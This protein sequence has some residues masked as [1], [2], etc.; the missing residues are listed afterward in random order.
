LTCECGA[1]RLEPRGLSNLI[2][3]LPAMRQLSIGRSVVATACSVVILVIASVAGVSTQQQRGMIVQDAPLFLLPDRAREPLLLMERGVEV[4]VIRR[5]GEW[6]NVTVHG[7]QWGDRTG[8]VEAKYLRLIAALPSAERL[9][10]PTPRTNIAPST[11]SARSDQ[12]TARVVRL[13]PMYQHPDARGGPILMLEADVIVHVI[14]IDGPW[15]NINVDGSRSGTRVGY[16]EEQYVD[17]IPVGAQGASPVAPRKQPT[18]TGPTIQQGS[19]TPSVSVSVPQ[20][21]PTS[22][23]PSVAPSTAQPPLTAKL[24]EVKIRGYVT[25]MRS[26]MDFDIEDYRITRD[27]AFVLDFE[28]A[29][30]DVTFQLQ[31]IRVGVE[32]EI[33]GVLDEQTRELKAKTIKVDLEQFRSVKQTAFVS[34]APEGIQLL[35]GTWAG[36]LK[37]DG[38]VIRVT[39]ATK[40]LFKPT[41]REKQLAELRGKSATREDDEFESLQSLDQVTVGMA[42]T[43]EGARDRETGKILA[44]R[45]EFSSNDLEDGE[46]KLWNSLKVSVKAP[47]GVKP[48]ELKINHVG[49]FKLLPD[50]DVQAY[51]TA[52]GERLIPSYQREMR[53]DDPRR[54][55]F[56]FHVVL[57]DQVNAFA[58]PNGIV[59]VFSGLLELLDNEA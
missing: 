41:K 23:T 34:R 21:P 5:H 11:I 42:M 24:K 51:V 2:Y 39:N 15:L 44:D 14:R 27:E 9:E 54:I 46:A 29:S 8:Y 37:A 47:Q 13:A 36:E 20:K 59:V 40:V 6:F 32:L 16:I 31:D 10:T 3:S 18:A 43:Y 7:S 48:G 55:P 1:L 58:T 22:S 25:E 52:L 30:P 19:N 4:D 33:R 17:L 53:L 12:T 26:P 38:Q 56:Q 45:I 28:N 49:K 35:D 57:T 50:P